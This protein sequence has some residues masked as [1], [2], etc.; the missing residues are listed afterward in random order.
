MADPTSGVVPAVVAG[1]GAFILSAI[2]VEPQPLFWALIGA[3]FGM[4]FAPEAGRLRAVAVFV[5]SIF[6]SALL[7]SWLAH[8]IEATGYARNS[9][10][11]IVA[12]LF[13]PLLSATVS[14]VPA[15]VAGLAARWQAFWGARP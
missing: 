2:G 15:F 3:V 1:F 12:A 13:H 7:G 9:M 10:A 5:A 8:Y 6:A 11:L 4:S 14:Q